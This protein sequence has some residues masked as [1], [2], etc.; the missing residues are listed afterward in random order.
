MVEVRRVDE[1]TPTTSGSA[2]TG[3]SGGG[4][5]EEEE[6]DIWCLAR[7]FNQADLDE[8]TWKADKGVANL[9]TP[10]SA[11]LPNED[12]PMKHSEG[13]QVA[14][15]DELEPERDSNIYD[16]EQMDIALAGVSDPD[17]KGTVEVVS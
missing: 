11:P 14:A 3:P 16:A 4:S 5:N 15:G 13:V 12:K 1:N 9:V 10:W 8:G 6:G 2:N 17:E 7:S